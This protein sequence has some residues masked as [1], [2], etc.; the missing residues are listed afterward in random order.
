MTAFAGN[1]LSQIG[2][3]IA[4]AAFF[5]VASIFYINIKIV[6]A[7]IYF[8]IQ[9][10]GPFLSKKFYYFVG[11]QYFFIGLIV[12]SWIGIPAL[13]GPFSDGGLNIYF[14]FLMGAMSFILFSWATSK[15]LKWGD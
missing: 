1:R 9:L 2:T 8:A 4:P 5:V 11:A 12:F 6:Y 7:L 3:S 10:L 14:R 13:E 15:I